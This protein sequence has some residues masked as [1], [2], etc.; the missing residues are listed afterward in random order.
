MRVTDRY[1]LLLSCRVSFRRK[2]KEENSSKKEESKGPSKK[3]EK[4]SFLF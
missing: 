2:K 1:V 4:V 3:D